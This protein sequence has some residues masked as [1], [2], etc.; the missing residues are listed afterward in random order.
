M[1][2]NFRLTS[3]TLL[4]K[5]RA[6][7]GK[8]ILGIALLAGLAALLPFL[9]MQ[10]IDAAAWSPADGALLFMLLFGAGLGYELIARKSRA[11]SY[12]A[13]AGLALATAFLLVVA[14]LA[15]G[16]VGSEQNPANR[17][18]VA[19]PLVGIAGAFLARFQPR[20]MAGAAFATAVTHA[21]VTG[22]AVVL[23]QPQMDSAEALLGL[24][25]VLGGNLFFVG[26]FIGS[27]LLFR[28]ASDAATTG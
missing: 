23:W 6:M 3:S 27:A 11:V 12:R 25:R 9:A 1:T 18:Y 15:V 26:L 20:G 19:V 24:A 28:R 10:F 17:L 5:V 14:N 8:R 16:L 4:T 21:V 13:A 22:I 2:R 7:E